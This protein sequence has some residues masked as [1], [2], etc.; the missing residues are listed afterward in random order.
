MDRLVSGKWNPSYSFASDVTSV[1]TFTAPL[2]FYLNQQVQKNW[3]TFS[4]IYGETMW[5]AFTVPMIFKGITQRIRPYAYQSSGA[6]AEKLYSAETKR[7]FLSGH[8]THSFS[9]AVFFAKVWSDLYPENR[10]NGLVWSVSLSL[11][12]ATGVFRCISGNHFPTDVLAGAALG[13]LIGW[14]V[15]ELHRVQQDY[16]IKNIPGRGTGRA[17]FNGAVLNIIGFR[18]R[19]T[20]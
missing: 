9:G 19:E 8:T 16:R 18:C 20:A 7:S 1:I 11:A 14:G 12:T 4:I 3:L 6:P 13:S 10:Y 5:L 15:P 17:G 2:L